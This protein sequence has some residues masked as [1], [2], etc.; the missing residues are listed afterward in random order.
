MNDTFKGSSSRYRE[1]LFSAVS[2]GFFFVLVGALFTITP[3]L[4]ERIVDFFENFDIL[5]VPNTTIWLPA[6]AQ[7][8]AHSDVYRAAEQFSFAL[9]VFQIVILALR[10]AAGSPVGKKAETVS[11]LVFWLGVGFLINRLLIEISILDRIGWFVFWTGVL[12][13]LGLSL[14]VR[15]IILAAA[16]RR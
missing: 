11:N 10:F 15:A 4:F 13:L 3:N 1:G 9:G 14:I 5:R 16:S 8:W 12:M 7:P 6:P 2:A